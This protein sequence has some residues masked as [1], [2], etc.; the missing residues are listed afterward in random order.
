M[1][2]PQP[3]TELG[4]DQLNKQQVATNPGNQKLREHCERRLIGLRSDRYSW[5]VHWRELADFLM[6]RRYMW[7]VTPNKGNRGAPMNQKIFDNTGTLALR[8]LAAGMMSGITSPG[9]P[10]F[11]L[12]IEDED[13]AN[14]DEVKDWLDQVR[15]LMLRVFAESNFYNALAVMYQDLAIFGTAPMII[16]ED[17]DDVIHCFNVAAGEYYLSNNEKLECDTLYREFTFSAYQMVQRFGKE[18]CSQDVRQAVENGG[19]GL[20]REKIV[21]HSIEANEDFLPGSAG[22]K[23]MAFREVYWESG[24]GNMQ[25]MRVR[26]FHEQPFV[27]PRWDIVG[28][29]AYGRS[30][31]MDALGDVKQL[32]IMTKRKAQALDKHVNP[33]MIADV[34]LKNEPASLVPGGVTYVANVANGVGFKPV[35]TVN[36]DFSGLVEDIKEVQARIKSTMFN[37]L[38]LMISQLDTVRTATEID[39]RREEKLVQLGPVLERFQN[40]ALDPTIDRV[41]NIMMRAGILPPLP[42]ALQ[43]GQHI[44]C[45]YVSMLAQAQKSA[46]TAGIE[47]LASFVGNLAAAHPDALDMVDFDDMIRVYNELLGNSPTIISPEDQVKKL[48]SARQQQAQASQQSQDSLAAA[49]GAQTLS[50]TD[51]GGGMNA[52][53]MMMNGQQKGAM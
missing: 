21:G 48:R 47:R 5:W 35:Y 19:A 17:Y 51:V 53:Q 49:Q 50:K 1:A 45:E 25:V 8:V 44:K 14:S 3:K 38:F 36:P 32:Q 42:Q 41:F 37:D 33:P 46:Q 43:G 28:N 2:Q 13:L 30:P 12:T 9:R 27:A 7:L 16:Y 15:D 10:W 31:A 22:F 4:N 39:A 23:G 6:P 52:L 26:G 24:E 29:D 18:N 11:T 40:E 34:S 20:T